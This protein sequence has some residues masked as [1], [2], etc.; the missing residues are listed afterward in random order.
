[1]N[2]RGHD[3]AGEKRIF[4]WHRRNNQTY[5]DA[6][7]HIEH[8]TYLV[9]EVADNSDQTSIEKR[10]TLWDPVGDITF[11]VIISRIPRCNCPFRV[12]FS[13]FSGLPA[14]HFTNYRYRQRLQGGRKNYT[15]GHIQYVLRWVLDCP[16]PL[17]WQHA[18]LF[19]ELQAVVRFSTA[20]LYA[21][22][23]RARQ[24]NRQCALCFRPFEG[25]DNMEARCCG[26]YVHGDCEQYAKSRKSDYTCVRHS[27]HLRWM[28]TAKATETVCKAVSESL[29]PQPEADGSGHGMASSS[30]DDGD[31]PVPQN[32][33]CSSPRRQ[34]PSRAAKEAVA[35][36]DAYTGSP[37]RQAPA[38]APRWS[39]K[40][41]TTPI[42]L[43][44]I[45]ASA[46]GQLG[47]S[48]VAGSSQLPTIT[49]AEASPSSAAAS[50][51]APGGSGSRAEVARSSSF[52]SSAGPDSPHARHEVR[53]RIVKL[54][55]PIPKSGSTFSSVTIP[56][57]DAASSPVHKKS[58]RTKT[59]GKKRT[60]STITTGA[61]ADQ[62]GAA[63]DQPAATNTA[64]TT[65]TGTTTQQARRNSAKMEK[66]ERRTARLLKKMSRLQDDS[67]KV[68]KTKKYVDQ[69][70][71]R[72]EKK[73]RK[74][75]NKMAKLSEASGV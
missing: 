41:S 67:E 26:L 27:S 72:L 50:R 69:E 1:M 74:V 36:P 53:T 7:E 22:N 47:R 21:L 46:K 35:R 71:A 73:M 51:P 24:P 25:Q 40:V 33:A 37:R 63:D 13:E 55:L 52:S 70:L 20:L 3:S 32:S 9:T 38:P 61:P 8:H 54:R 57:A 2:A 62:A 75:A 59:S 18:M 19:K 58:K 39:P 14:A 11:D 31:L 56:A 45:P 48:R 66:R 16:E 34:L 6:I 10:F 17:R 64:P 12:S 30:S 43:P 28:G 29:P 44:V 23:E 68:R 5:R 4:R 42:P 49:E 65:A 15:C 60:A